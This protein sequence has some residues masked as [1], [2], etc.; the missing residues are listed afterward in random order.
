[1]KNLRRRPT[2]KILKITE[3]KRRN[4]RRTVFLDDGRVFGISGDVFITSGIAAGDELSEQDITRLEQAENRQKVLAAALNLLSYRQRSR[5]E[6]ADR[7]RNKGWP[8]DAVVPV[9][10]QLEEQGY[11][12]D[13]EFALAFGRDKIR[14][15]SLG[16]QALRAELRQKRVEAS[17]IDTVINELYPEGFEAELITNLL[18]KKRIDR[19]NLSAGEWKKISDLL[20]RKGF[21]WSVI[22]QVLQTNE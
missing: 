2:T 19:H 18:K 14:F 17:V 11:L 22:K 9:L 13:R 12:N 21:N 5:G 8:A 16:P 10:D 7:L 1:M 3:Q 20:A 6:L 15:R 4:D